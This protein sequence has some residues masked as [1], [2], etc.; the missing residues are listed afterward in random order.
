[1]PGFGFQD[2]ETGEWSGREIDL[3]REIGQ[4]MAAGA[5]P[6]RPRAA[7]EECVSLRPVTVGARVAALRPWWARLVDAIALPK[8]W[9]MCALNGSWWHLGIRGE[10]PDWLCPTTA[11]H[12]QDFVAV[13]YYYGISGLGPYQLRSLL[14]A[15]GG[16]YD[17]APVWPAGLRRMLRYVADLFPTL[18]VMIVENGSVPRVSGMTRSTYLRQ[19]L[20]QVRLAVADGVPVAG[21]LCWSITSNREWGSSPGPSSDFGLYRVDLDGDPS[22]VRVATGDVRTYRAL[23]E[24]LQPPRR[25]GD[26]VE[27]PHRELTAAR[28]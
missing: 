2:P 6:S 7:G 1:V 18:P 19:H 13:D 24:E 9:L 11:H 25:P 22:L 5:V 26:G 17:E 12:A 8:D 21:Y 14:R 4:R 10:L 28:Q 16:R 27:P 23:I 20:E 15:A 3:V